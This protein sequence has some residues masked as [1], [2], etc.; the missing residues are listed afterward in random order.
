MK[1]LYTNADCF[2]VTKQTELKCYIEDKSP[3]IIAITEILPKNTNFDI[4]SSHYE[5]EGY[6]MFTSDLTTGRG[7]ALYVKSEIPATLTKLNNDFQECIWCNIKLTGSDNLMIGCVYRSPSSNSDNNQKLL[8]MFLNVK[9]LNPSHL[10]IMGDFNLKEIDWNINNSR[11]TEVHIASQFLEC[12]R[13]CFLYQHV[14]N[15]TRYRSGF[16]PSLLDLVFTNEENMIESINHMSGLG[17]SDHLQLEFI[18]NCYTEITQ[19]LVTKLIFFK[20]N[21][22]SLSGELARLNWLQEFNGCDLSASWEK[23]TEKLSNLI[24]S[25][26]PVS[27][28]SSGSAKKSPY[29]TQRCHEAIRKKHTKWEKYL[30][31]KTNQNYEIYK[32]SRNI[33]KAEMRRSKYEYEKD[34]T[35][36]IK[37]DSKLFWSYVRSKQKT[38]GKLGQLETENGTLTNDSLVKAEVLNS[39]FASVFETE[40]PGALPEFIDRDF[41]EV[42]SHIEITETLV[43]KTIDRLKPS[44]SQGPDNIHPKL[45]KECKKSIITPLTMI[46]KKSLQESVLPS[47][48]KQANVTAI[49]KKGPRTKPQNYRPISLTSVP[50]KLMERIIRDH[51]VEHM[52]R[53]DFFSPFQHGFVSGKSCVTQLLEFLDNL[54]EALDQGDDVD[55]IYLDFSKAFD[56]LQHRR[57]MKKLWGYGIRGKV[58]KWIKE[59]LANR[60]QQV[61]V[62]G[63]SSSTKP[64]TSGVPQGS[65]LGPILFV[66]YINDL[67]D[68]IQCCIRLFADDSKIYWR[69]SRIEHVEILQSCLNKAVTWADIWEMFFN[70]LKCHHLHVGKN[71]MGQIYTMQSPDG[72][73]RLETVES[74]KDLGVI[75]DSALSFGEHIGSKISI[76]NRNLGLIFKTFTFMDKDMFLNLFKSLVRPHLE[77]ASTVWSPQHK[78]DMIAI[79]NVQRRATRM[80]SCL[81]G[82]TYP[83][84]LKILGLPSLEYRRERADM[85]QVYKIMNDI[86]MVNKEK[87]FTMSQYTGTRGH[88]FKIYKKR[89]RLNI[90]GNYFSNRVVE[91]WNE[92]PEHT[93]MAPTLNSFKSRLNKCWH[94]H[95]HKFN[96]WCY[97]PGERTRHWQRHPNTSTEVAEPN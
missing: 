84:R 87:L 23:L 2:T 55:I 11:S 93:V 68:V 38:K 6:S 74:E 37:T 12:V 29:I 19:T 9:D 82:K 95:P 46:F 48:W 15:Y 13:D 17:K 28:V 33:V 58:Y 43:E 1:I 53:N 73:V 16:E 71:S 61:V 35:T 4:D 30:H 52:T 7:C 66:I 72:E 14:K 86:D 90:R 54:T 63:Q 45:V 60:T 67:P 27:K 42:L 78:K 3:D 59:F 10:L 89:F 24:E 96:P 18:F 92:L 83:E 85:V 41:D 22:T 39:Y 21:Y 8:E 69:V 62:D 88:S 34:L 47:I 65:V 36:K 57:L 5:I 44:K 76:A 80:L 97:I 20:G 81:R 79:E 91:Q 75:I 51:I 70:L 26:I 56:K 50:C 64:V 77:Y 94:G 49:Y 25:H 32:E 40:D 31:C